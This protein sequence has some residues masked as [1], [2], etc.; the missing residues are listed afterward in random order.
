MAIVMRLDRM[1]AYR[2][3]PLGKLAERV[4]IADSNLSKLKNGRV[5]G[6]RFKTLDA[7]C[8]ELDCGVGDLIEYVED[9][10]EAD[11]GA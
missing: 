4:G 6:V 8:R 5:I 9:E 2:K 3:M 10:E 1:M 7:I 11:P